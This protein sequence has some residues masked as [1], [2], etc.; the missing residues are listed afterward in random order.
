MYFRD[1]CHYMLG[2]CFWL[3]VD[4]LILPPWCSQPQNYNNKYETEFIFSNLLL[5]S[6]H[7]WCVLQGITV[8]KEI[9]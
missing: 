6:K 2:L 1:A 7:N 9:S 3:I 8:F 4:L 5:L